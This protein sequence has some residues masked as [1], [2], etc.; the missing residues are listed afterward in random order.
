MN[1]VYS[2]ID[3]ILFHKESK[4]NFERWKC[5]IVQKPSTAYVYKSV[6]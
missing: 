5:S 2:E 3:K 6:R 1:T 4:N